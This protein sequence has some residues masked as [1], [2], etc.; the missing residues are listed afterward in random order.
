MP[1][2]RHVEFASRAGVAFKWPKNIRLQAT[3]DVTIMLPG[4]ILISGQPIDGVIDA[5]D[6][7]QIGFEKNTDGKGFKSV[8]IALK[9]GQAL[10]I[11]RSSMA[12]AYSS[13]RGTIIFKVMQE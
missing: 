1:A 11:R 8:M 12:I 5:P 7:V 3:E 4:A 2:D 6:D 13:G 9:A 10:A